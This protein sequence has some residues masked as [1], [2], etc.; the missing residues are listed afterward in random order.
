MNY[1]L[2]LGLDPRKHLGKSIKEMFPHLREVVQ[3]LQLSFIIC[4]IMLCSPH[5][6]RIKQAEVLI[7]AHM[8]IKN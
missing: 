4:L 3:Y 8:N 2:V 6:H 1:V 5:P 7:F